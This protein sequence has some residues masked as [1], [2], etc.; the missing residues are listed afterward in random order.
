ML[1]GR[2]EPWTAN[3]FNVQVSRAGERLEELLGKYDEDYDAMYEAR[4]A[5][6]QSKRAASAMR[7]KL[8]GEQQAV[9]S[10]YA[11]IELG[12]RDPAFALIEA[13]HRAGLK[14]PMAEADYDGRLAEALS[15]VTKNGKDPLLR[16]LATWERVVTEWQKLNPGAGRPKLSLIRGGADEEAS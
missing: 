12:R 1:L 8:T 16:P 14:G 6:L 4:L 7:R 2:D 3:G 10:V 5:G 15:V 11:E 9:L 13:G